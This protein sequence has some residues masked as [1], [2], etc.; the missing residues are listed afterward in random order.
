MTVRIFTVVPAM[1]LAL[2][3]TAA[4]AQTAARPFPQFDQASLI[5]HSTVLLPYDQASVIAVNAAY[6]GDGSDPCYLRDQ[7]ELTREPGYSVGTGA[8]QVC[9][10]RIT[11]GGGSNPFHRLDRRKLPR[12]PGYGIGTGAARV[13][14][15]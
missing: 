3:A 7:Q 14:S 2:G 12:E 10:P 13:S 15:T 8:A 11:I 9:D 5:D 1:V 6:V 4:L